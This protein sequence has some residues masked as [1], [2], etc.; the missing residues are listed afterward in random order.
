MAGFPVFWQRQKDSAQALPKPA[1]PQGGGGQPSGQP[2]HNPQSRHGY[3]PKGDINPPGIGRV[4]AMYRRE[5]SFTNLLPWL[6]YAPETQSFLLSDGRGLGALFDIRPAGCEAR[7]EEWLENFRDKL[8]IALGALPESEPPWVVQ[9][10]VQDEPRLES[11]ADG[12][13]AYVREGAKGSRFSEA[14]LAVLREHLGD[15]CRH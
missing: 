12:I 15:I 6:D 4:A 8:Q 2:V 11:L 9:F 1:S 7:P 5:P 10:F 3:G 14:W 13:A